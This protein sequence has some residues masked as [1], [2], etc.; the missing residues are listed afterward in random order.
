VTSLCHSDVVLAS[1]LAEEQALFAVQQACQ[2]QTAD[3]H[4][5]IEFHFAI[6][7][8]FFNVDLEFRAPIDDRQVT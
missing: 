3:R 4:I 2:V 1:V 6:F 5:N 8:F 7:P